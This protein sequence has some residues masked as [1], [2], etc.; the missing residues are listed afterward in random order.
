MRKHVSSFGLFLLAL[1]LLT[2]VPSMRA[3]IFGSIRGVV[4]DPQHRPMTGVEV[5]LKS[6]SSAWSQTVQTEPD[7]CFSFSAVPLGDYVVTVTKG[8]FA[9]ESEKITLKADSSPVLHFQLKI[10]SVNQS[11]TV[12]A[13]A[14]E[15]A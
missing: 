12:S 11:T 3:T 14:Q 9:N 2:S 8:G 7:G 5:T 1:C 10:A 13:E 15:E 4:H 6:V